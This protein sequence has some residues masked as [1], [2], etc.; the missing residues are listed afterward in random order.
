MA[1]NSQRDVSILIELGHG[2]PSLLQSLQL[3]PRRVQ[4]L[5]LLR[6]VEADEAVFG[7]TE[8]A[9]AGDTGDADLAHEPFGGL[10][11]RRVAMSYEAFARP[12]VRDSLSP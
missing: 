8:E 1:I 10:A 3:L 9:G 4:R 5:D 2:S 7:F 12:L 11:C 6:E